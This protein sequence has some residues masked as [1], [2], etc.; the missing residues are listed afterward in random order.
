MKKL[1]GLLLFCMVLLA[2]T[3]RADHGRGIVYPN[4]YFKMPVFYSGSKYTL[5]FTSGAINL[6]QTTDGHALIAGDTIQLNAAGSYTYMRS[7]GLNGT[8]AFHIVV[9]GNGA[10]IT[11]PSS[12]QSIEWFNSSYVDFK[13]VVWFNWYG[14]NTMDYTLHDLLFDGG[15]VTWNGSSNRNNGQPWMQWDNAS[16]PVSMVFDGTKAKTF[17][18]VAFIGMVWAGI[19][20]TYFMTLGT[21]WG[22]ADDNRSICTDFTFAHLLMQDFRN[23]ASGGGIDGNQ[24]GGVFGTCFNIKIDHNVVDRLAASNAFQRA[25]IVAFAMYGNGEINNNRMDSSYAQMVRAVPLRWTGL[26]GYDKGVYIWNNIFHNGYDYSAFE[27][28]QNNKGDRNS[29]YLIYPTNDTV[30]FNTV[31]RTRASSYLASNAGATYRYFA[32]IMDDANQTPYINYLAYN[33]IGEP[34]SDFTYDPTSNRNYEDAVISSAN[35]NLLKTGNH[36]FQHWTTA[37]WDDTLQFRPAAGS[38]FIDAGVTFPFRTGDFFDNSF[39]NAPDAG[40]VER[41]APAQTRTFIRR[42]RVSVKR[43]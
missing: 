35:S 27:L 9:L 24:V 40:A 20:D 12:F 29:T 33:I 39:Y 30:V 19:S 4:G 7:Q 31:Y 1:K 37:L 38:A 16:S 41:P 23:T 5:S 21:G 28:G 22:G 15:S 17:H 2:Y 8:S 25:H 42:G 43:S 13:N 36:H 32:R 11:S 6:A 18:D 14:K 10:Q 3:A 26:T 34:E